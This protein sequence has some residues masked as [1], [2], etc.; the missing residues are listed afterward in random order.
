VQALFE[1]MAP[2]QNPE[3]RSRYADI[4][5][6]VNDAEFMNYLQ[7]TNPAHHALLRN[8]CSLTVLE[9]S[10]KIN[11]VPTE[12]I[13]ELDCR[14]LP[15][16]DPDLF[17]EELGLI[18]NDPNVE[19]EKLMGF[20]P[21]VSSQDTPLY[22]LIESVYESFYPGAWVVPGVA[23]GFTDSHFF[24][25]MGIISYGF[26]PFVVPPADRRG[27]HGNNERISVANMETGTL[28][29]IDLLEQFTTD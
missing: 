1:G 19:I 11:V 26:G 22:E 28:L 7:L 6:A 18:I 16:Q 5:N 14:L 24:R 4:T 20:T 23:T 25:D 17:I 15:D 10:S 8:T 27:V 29:M 9:G 2:Y 12:A 13:L 3:L 21:A